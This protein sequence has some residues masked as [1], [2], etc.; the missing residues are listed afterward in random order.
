MA[1]IKICYNCKHCGQL[2]TNNS[3]YCQKEHTIVAG[4]SYCNYFEAEK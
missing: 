1:R 4:T 3:I 2:L